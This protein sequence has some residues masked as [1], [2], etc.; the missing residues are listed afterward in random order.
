[1]QPEKLM[2]LIEIVYNFDAKNGQHSA[3]IIVQ[4]SVNHRI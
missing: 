2:C 4:L 3:I 1:M